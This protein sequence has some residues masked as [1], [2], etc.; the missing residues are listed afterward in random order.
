MKSF[1]IRE[2]HLPIWKWMSKRQVLLLFCVLLANTDYSARN[3]TYSVL[4]FPRAGLEISCSVS[5]KSNPLRDYRILIIENDTIFDTIYADLTLPIYIQLD[6]NKSYLLEFSKPGFMERL[7][8]V[9]TKVPEEKDKKR[10]SYDFEIEMPFRY[11]DTG[12]Y[13]VQPVAKIIYD[14]V[15]GYFGYDPEYAKSI[16]NIP[17]EVSDPEPKKEKSPAK[18][19]RGRK[20][21]ARKKL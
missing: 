9:D 12:S 18:N 13:A 3:A 5:Q 8:L 7:V 2:F 4:A 19:K 17:V 21:V 10:F 20:Q 15:N 16:G 14:E 1:T 11:C 6:L